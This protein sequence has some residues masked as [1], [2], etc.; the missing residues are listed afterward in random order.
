MVNK[1]LFSTGASVRGSAPNQLRLLETR[2]V[3]GNSSSTSPSSSVPIGLNWPFGKG[4]RSTEPVRS[5]P[6]LASSLHQ[7]HCRPAAF[8]LRPPTSP[9]A[10][11]HLP[12]SACPL[13][14]WATGSCCAPGASPTHTVMLPFISDPQQ[15]AHLHF[16]ETLLGDPRRTRRLVH[17]AAAMAEDPA[18]SIPR[19]CGNWAD[20]KAAYRLFQQS[21]VTFE[22]VCQPHFDMRHQVAGGCFLVLGD[23]TQL[24][25][26]SQRLIEGVG[27][28]G[29]GSGRGLL[30]HSGL[31]RCPAVPPPR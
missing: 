5:V 26:G 17:F 25:F 24:D 29:N 14:G 11:K 9:I 13:L 31:S 1:V 8:S 20:T 19:I 3:P 30:L 22:A 12:S 27:P 16:G 4:L 6:A 15:W 2:R 18:G 10:T 21:E 23:T 7:D 28:L